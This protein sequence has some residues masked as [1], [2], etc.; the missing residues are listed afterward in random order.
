[1]IGDKRVLAVVPARGGS[2]GIPGKNLKV[3]AGRSLLH[4]T[5]DQ[6]MKSSVIDD[7]VVSSDDAE[8]LRHATDVDG[9][10]T[11]TRPIDLAS[12]DSAMWPVVLHA[13]D[14]STKCDIVVLL[15]P[16]SPL[17]LSSDIDSAVSLLVDKCADS[18]MSVCES[19][20]SPYWM[21]TIDDEGKLRRV[22]PK[23]PAATRQELP[24]CFEINGAIYAVSARWFRQALAFVDDE[25]LAYVMPRER[26]I[27]VD[28]PEDLAIA[29]FLLR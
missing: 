15:Q 16:T 19:A 2:K 18:V 9:V 4:R 14:N 26:S 7:V 21:F 11:I 28:T 29:E 6:A 20:T 17:R 1:M 13:L 24:I 27:D 5:L 23:V 3:I 10:R 22:L 8:I 25:T 12:D